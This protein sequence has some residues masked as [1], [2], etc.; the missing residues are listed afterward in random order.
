MKDESGTR[1][2]GSGRSQILPDLAGFGRFG[3]KTLALRGDSDTGD[4]GGTET[5]GTG[6]PRGIAAN[7]LGWGE[8][9]G[10]GVLGVGVFGVWC[11]VFG[12]G[13]WGGDDGATE[14]AAMEGDACLRRLGR[15]VFRV[16]NRT[17]QTERTVGRW[18]WWRRDEHS[19][20]GAGDAAANRARTCTAP[21]GQDG[22]HAYRLAA[23]GAE[24]PS[25]TGPAR[26]QRPG[27]RSR[28]PDS[29]SKWPVRIRGYSAG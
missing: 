10:V 21:F 9:L 17:R 29:R 13:G 24:R 3:A 12:F 6:D 27:G 28:W 8:V 5:H 1:G 26:G 7:G 16:P 15:G 2:A 25:V 18:F 19:G 20:R 4:T 11:W 14:V 22:F 23:V